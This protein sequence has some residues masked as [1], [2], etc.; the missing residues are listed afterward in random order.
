MSAQLPQVR[1]MLDPASYATDSAEW[2]LAEFLVGWKARD[3][4]RM[5]Q[6]TQLTWRSSNDAQMI[7]TLFGD[8]SL[9]GAEITN[10]SEADDLGGIPAPGA[11]V[12]FVVR[13]SYQ[14]IFGDKTKDFDVRVICETAPY[15]A[16]AGGTWGVNPFSVD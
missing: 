7:S 15:T 2:A 9:V 1:T 5:Y 13:I 8:K 10:K 3:W 12:D 4:N 14:S 6:V 11:V 16:D